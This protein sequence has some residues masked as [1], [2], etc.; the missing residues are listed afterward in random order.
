[1]TIELGNINKGIPMG[2]YAPGEG[3][4]GTAKVTGVDP[5]TVTKGSIAIKIDEQAFQV[6]EQGELSANLD[7]IDGGVAGSIY[8]ADPQKI[9]ANPII[10]DALSGG[11]AQSE[12]IQVRDGE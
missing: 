1:M 2:S 8:P 10:D 11:Q 4:G 9:D 12:E 6:N 5:I 7:K 3:G